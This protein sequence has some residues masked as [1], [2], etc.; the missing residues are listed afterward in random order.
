MAIEDLGDGARVTCA[1][2]SA[3]ACDALIGAD[4]LWSRTRKMVHDDGD[5]ICAQYVAYRGTIPVEE[6]PA[7]SDLENMTI[8]VGPEIHFVQYVVHEGKLFNQVAVF[9][10]H[11][12][13]PGHEYLDGWG[14]VEELDERFRTLCPRVRNAV[15]KIKRNRRW[16]MF[17]RLPIPNW[18]RGHITLL[19]DA[20]IPCC[21]TLRRGHVRRWKTRCAWVRAFPNI[22]TIRRRHLPLIKSRGYNGRHASRGPHVSSGS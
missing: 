9:R 17:D 19:G 1:D 15:T 21:N 14:T 8:W 3:Y 10:S 13:Q 11:R 20:A 18:T 16:P 12:Y 7:G 22:R 6:A 5:P 4:G 2:G